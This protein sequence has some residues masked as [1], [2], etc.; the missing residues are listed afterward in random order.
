VTIEQDR[1]SLRQPPPGFD[2]PLNLLISPT[3]CWRAE[4]VLTGKRLH[5][6]S[7]LA[8]CLA[9][10]FGDTSDGTLQAIF[11]DSSDS[12]VLG[13]NGNHDEVPTLWSTDD[14]G[15]QWRATVPIAAWPGN[16]SLLR[17][18]TP[19]GDSQMNPMEGASIGCGG[20]LFDH[21]PRPHDRESERVVGVRKCGGDPRQP[22]AHL[23]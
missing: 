10:N 14:G 8:N 15:G 16:P 2:V 18:R 20:T 9:P 23:V 12:V 3:D 6:R 22:Q 13:Y 19:V 4:K 5:R 7:R 17:N 11:L 1:F 21:E